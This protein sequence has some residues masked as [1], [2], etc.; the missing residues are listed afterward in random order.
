MLEAETIERALEDVMLGS[1][2]FFIFTLRVRLLKLGT[3]KQ[4]GPRAE[5]AAG[6]SAEAVPGFGSGLRRWIPAQDQYPGAV[7]IK[8]FSML[9]RSDPTL[10]LA[11]GS[12]C[13]LQVHLLGP[14]LQ[15][16]LDG[17]VSTRGQLWAVQ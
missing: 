7:S 10:N 16:S 11:V 9:P 12:C 17:E 6:A 3:V 14:E 8:H 13:D 2:L 5:E 1:V 15:R 4:E